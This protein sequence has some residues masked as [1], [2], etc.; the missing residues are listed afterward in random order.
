MKLKML[1]SSLCAGTIALGLLLS[2]RSTIAENRVSPGGKTLNLDNYTLTFEESFGYP[3]V[4]AKAPFSGY[5]PGR[6][7]LA[8]TP[9]NG[10]FGDATFINPGPTGPFSFGPE[11]LTITASKN[12][13]G[14]WV[15]GLICSV[16]RDGPGQ[17]GF[18]QK[19]GYF[20]MRAKL[21][22]G[23]GTWPAF[24]LIGV[25]KAD[26]SAEIDVLEYYGQFTN[27]FH[28][29]VHH[30]VGGKDIFDLQYTVDVPD[31]LL[32]SG[33]HNFGVSIEDDETRF[34]L[35]GK[36]YAAFKTE[37]FLKQPMYMLVNLALGGGW[38]I[39]KLK[40]PVK[41]QVEYIRVYKMSR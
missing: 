10:D 7:W 9:W 38:P 18:S 13:D 5:A 24:W 6:H 22:D 27:G 33:F 34:F 14:K 19:F 8:H 29:V 16:D 26:G 3:N 39:D 2:A 11:G 28:T 30:W 25:D 35:D 20:E 37:D 23:P 17:Q 36:Q 12:A 40:S 15:S 32:S 41:M 1:A 4:V 31:M 21:P